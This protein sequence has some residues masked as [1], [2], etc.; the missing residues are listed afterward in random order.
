MLFYTLYLLIENK[1]LLSEGKR[2]GR[3]DYLINELDR[4][5]E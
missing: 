5:F 2:L 4:K 3:N 1:N